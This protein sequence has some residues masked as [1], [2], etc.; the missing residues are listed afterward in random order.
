MNVKILFLNEVIDKHDSHRKECHHKRISIEERHPWFSEDLPE[1]S[2]HVTQVT[3]TEE[4][5]SE[6]DDGEGEYQSEQVRN[7]ELVGDLLYLLA[8]HKS[9]NYHTS[10]MHCAPYYKGI[11]SSMPETAHDEYNHRVEHPAC[12]AASVASEREVDIVAKPSRER[13]MPSAPEVGY[14]LCKVRSVEVVLQ[15]N[16]E[17]PSATNSH[18]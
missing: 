16:A 14:G 9:F 12:F 13:Y 1:D 10:P 18:Q 2:H 6:V 17:E 3:H 15:L 7:R 5:P 11:C 8:I 4:H